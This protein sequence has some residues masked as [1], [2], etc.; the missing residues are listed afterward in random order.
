MYCSPSQA[1]HTPKVKRG[2]RKWSPTED[3]VLISA[4]LNTSKDAV[5]GNEQKGN[6]FWSRIADYYAASPNLK[7]VE[8]RETDHIKQR[9]AKIN[10]GVC[11]FVG[12]YE[13]ALKQQSSGQN[14]NDVMKLAH[15]IFTNDYDAKFSLE[16]AWREL[17]HDQKW[18]SAPST[19]ATGQPKRRKTQKFAHC[20]SSQPLSHGVEEAMPR[21]IGVKAAKA[22]AKKTVSKPRSVEE[23]GK[24][25]TVFQ[26]MWEIKK[27]DNE[28]N[29]KLVQ[30]KM[31]DSLLSKTEPLTEIE[32]ALKNKLINDF[33]S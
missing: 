22:K 15:Q 14:D 18:C 13:A 9:W 25:L 7:G 16:H 6:A 21:P 1:A 27:Q 28:M 29:A 4:W 24:A 23:E 20:G 8:R 17:R 26:S 33:L 5:I 19:K 31:L 2:R 11:K 10:D 12:S 32:E 30:N 3:M